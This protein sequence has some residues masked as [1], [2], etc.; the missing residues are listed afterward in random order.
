MLDM[1]FEPIR[2][3]ESLNRYYATKGVHHTMMFRCYNF[4]RKYRCVVM[5]SWINIFLAIGRVDSSSESITQKVVWV[6]ESDKQ[7]F[8][9]EGLLNATGKDS[10]TLV[11]VETKKGADS[12]EDFLYHEGYAC[13]VSM[14]TN[15]RGNR[16][17]VLYQFLL[18][19]KPD[20]HGYSS[21]NKRD[22]A[23]QTWNTLSILTWWYWI[24]CTLHWLYRMCRIPWPCHLIL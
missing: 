7:S 12:L 10:L 6:E 15:L 21:S 20:S 1:G 5:I 23:Y 4:L 3:I 2:Y 17:E 13:T 24:I 11:F 22:W 16:E 18:R 14:Q 9:L 8:L 19:K